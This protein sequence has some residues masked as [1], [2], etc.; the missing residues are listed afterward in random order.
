MDEGRNYEILINLKWPHE[1]FSLGYE[2]V[3]P[4]EDEPFTTILL[5]L[6]FLTLIVNLD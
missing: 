2:I 6:G 5:Y 3:P 4:N 1:G